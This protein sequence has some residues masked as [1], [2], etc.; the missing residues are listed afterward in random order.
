MALDD[1]AVLV[2]PLEYRKV[3]R[4]VDW[5]A[6]IV[7]I[8]LEHLELRQLEYALQFGHRLVGIPGRHVG[9]AEEPVGVQGHEPCHRVVAPPRR[10]E[11]D[12]AHRRYVNARHVHDAHVRLRRVVHPVVSLA[13]NMAVHI[14]DGGVH[15]WPP[16]TLFRLNRVA[17][18]VSCMS[19]RRLV[20]SR[21]IS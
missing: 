9:H 14:D 13:A 12:T 18:R 3:R 15:W 21:S 19:S 1:D 11:E 20:L 6:E 2:A 8:E 17:E 7:G 4:V 16:G 5:R 10:V